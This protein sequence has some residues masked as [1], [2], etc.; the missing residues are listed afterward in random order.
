MNGDSEALPP[1]SS[2]SAQPP[3]RGFLATVFLYDEGLRAGWR[4]LIYLAFAAL[5][6]LATDP[7]IRHFWLAEIKARAPR[8]LF[9]QEVWLFA[10]AFGAALIMSRIEKRAPGVYG[11][12]L[13]EAFRKLFWVGALLGLAEVSALIGLIHAAGGYSFGTFVLHGREV[14][15]YGVFWAFLFLAVGLFEEFLFRGYVQYTL[16]TGIGF[17]PAAI[18]L[19]AGFGYVH[20]RN[21]GEGWVGALSIVEVGIFL[22]FTLRRTGSLWLAVGLHAVFD[23]GETFLYSVPNSGIVMP[24]HL[25][26]SSLHGPAWVSGGTVGPEGSVFSFLTIGILFYVIHKLYPAKSA[27]SQHVQ[28][29]AQQA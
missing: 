23:Y 10:V 16:A 15:R 21:P 7:I 5:L 8:G 11:L 13:R 12:P 6:M 17:W 22:A 18:L 2:P 4:L 27:G 26:N 1:D 24:G 14:L 25:S 9:V 28:A 20:L 29:A 3:Q 19:S